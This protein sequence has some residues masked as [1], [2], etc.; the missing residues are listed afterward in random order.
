MK[1]RYF[2]II[3]ICLFVF[4][5][6]QKSKKNKPPTIISSVKKDNTIIL[7]LTDPDDSFSFTNV[8]DYVNILPSIDGDMEF[9]PN[10]I[11]TVS[12]PETDLA[13]F[14]GN[15]NNMEID[16]YTNFKMRD[17]TFGL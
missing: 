17:L 5:Y 16:S 10:E 12:F 13:R 14:R 8:P 15:T 7:K 2:F 4:V 6:K 3:M 9:Y 11:V 1:S